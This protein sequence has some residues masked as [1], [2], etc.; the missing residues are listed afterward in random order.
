MDNQ[1]MGIHRNYLFYTDFTTLAM[2]K[3][4][5]GLSRDR[6]LKKQVLPL[7]YDDIVKSIHQ[8]VL[9]F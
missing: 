5:L 2:F 1:I 6:N 8:I 4:N 9:H 7:C 3:S